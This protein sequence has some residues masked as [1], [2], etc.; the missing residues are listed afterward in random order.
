MKAAPKPFTI[1]PTTA[2][3][4]IVVRRDRTD[5]VTSAWV[6]RAPRGSLLAII[7]V[8]VAIDAELERATGR[9]MKVG[10]FKNGTYFTGRET[11]VA[12]DM[13]ILGADAD[14]HSVYRK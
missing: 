12:E 4:G 9:L 3:V 11:H 14:P 10:M 8:P 5:G 1:T 13:P 2:I 7:E 6:L